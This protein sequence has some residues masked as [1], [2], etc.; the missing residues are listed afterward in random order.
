MKEH[1]NLIHRDVKPSNIL[2]NRQGQ[3]KICDF[4]ISGHLTNSV[5]KTRN[6]GCKPYMPPERVEGDAMDSYD[7]RADVWSLGITL[8]SCTLAQGPP[9]RS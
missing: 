6:A 8:V 9:L 2:L 5:A 3:I 4:G 7:V 1:M